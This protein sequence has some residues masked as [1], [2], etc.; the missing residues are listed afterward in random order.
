MENVKNAF[1]LFPKN[2]YFCPKNVN[3][4]KMTKIKAFLFF[5]IFA[6]ISIGTTYAQERKKLEAQRAKTQKDIE[7]AEKL[8]KTTSQKKQQS[9]AEYVVT[10]KKIELR[11]KNINQL[12][13]EI[14]FLDHSIKYEND[15]VLLLQKY[16]EQLRNEYV[17]IIQR[18]YKNYKSEDRLMYIFSSSD[19][20]QAYRRIKFLHLYSKYRKDQIIAIEQ[21]RREIEDKI[22]EL[23]LLQ[24]SKK[25]L[26]DEQNSERVKLSSERN[27]QEKTMK[28]LTA[29]EQQIKADLDKKQK[30]AN[31]LSR[32]IQQ[33]IA[34]EVEKIKKGA[35]TYQLTPEEKL[36]NDQFAS[37]AR[38]LPW[39]LER[40]LIT[41]KFGEHNHPVLRGI[42]VRNDG[43]D[44]STNPGEKVRAVFN[45]TVKNII[46]IPG[47]NRVVI[48]RHGSYLSVYANLVDVNVKPG[49]NVKTKQNIGTLATDKESNMSILKFQIW[50]ENEKQDPERWL[51]TGA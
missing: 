25:T 3:K 37:N 46:V 1:F 35:T 16:L 14:N 50:K 34:A 51:T 9:V 48:I 40:G 28:D 39:P 8:L 29:Q 17:K 43:V 2:N 6:I 41:E 22:N 32:K 45:G 27:V 47:M 23:T 30:L 18:S 5:L 11:A 26:L 13:R 33:L 44:I 36:V 20:S 42:K 24:S 4:S 31:D 15:S 49:D 12:N 19:L 10:K 38:K 7:Y 21:V